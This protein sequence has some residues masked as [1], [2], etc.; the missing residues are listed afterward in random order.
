M[1]RSS[2]SSAGHIKKLCKMK[3]ADVVVKE[4]ISNQKTNDVSLCRGKTKRRVNGTKVEARQFQMKKVLIVDD[5]Y[6]H[7]STL[8]SFLSSTARH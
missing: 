7:F 5:G 1:T 3:T 8:P 2:S 4:M 6:I